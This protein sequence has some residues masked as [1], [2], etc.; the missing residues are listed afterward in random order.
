MHVHDKRAFHPCK[1]K[2]KKKNLAHFAVAT[3][4]WY[5]VC[6]PG[7]VLTVR[8][9]R[10]R[11]LCYCTSHKTYRYDAPLTNRTRYI[12]P[13]STYHQLHM[14]AH[15]CLPSPRA[16]LLFAG[17]ISRLQSQHFLQL[18]PRLLPTLAHSLTHVNRHCA[19]NT[20]IPRHNSNCCIIKQHCCLSRCVH[21]SASTCWLFVATKS[22]YQSIFQS[23]GTIN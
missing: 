4:A 17:V 15:R 16:R 22:I 18:S 9:G 20:Y 13:G 14:A 23:T 6:L 10:H 12:R 7:I 21:V 19:L 2:K 8:Q 1:N 3:T 11:N 5:T